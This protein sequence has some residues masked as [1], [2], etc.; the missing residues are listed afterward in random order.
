MQGGAGLRFWAKPL[1][2]GILMVCAFCL[3][4]NAFATTYQ[5]AAN[6]VSDADQTLRSAFSVVS[7][8]EQSGANVSVLLPRLD[9]AGSALTLAEEALGGGNYSGAQ[10]LA[11]VCKSIASGVGGDAV[12]LKNEA[13]AASGNWWITVL[14]SIGGSA[15]F[16]L[17]LL[18]VWHRF[19]LGYLK[20]TLNSRPEV[21][22]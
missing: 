11:S 14:F 18:F 17:V 13:V 15:V 5:E 22:E 6:K 1:A 10:N 4:Q 20:K 16:G 19:K 7:D 9:A 21:A 3:V 12:T 2:V 8:A